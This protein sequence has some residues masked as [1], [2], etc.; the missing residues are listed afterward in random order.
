MLY[1][2]ETLFA[3]LVLGSYLELQRM[4]HFILQNIK[5]D[6]GEMNSSC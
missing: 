6:N 5:D 1:S 2:G 3:V 4:G